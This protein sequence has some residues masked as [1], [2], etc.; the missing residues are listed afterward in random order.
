MPSTLVLHPQFEYWPSMKVKGPVCENGVVMWQQE[1]TTCW[2]TPLPSTAGTGLLFQAGGPSSGCSQD[3]SK[4]DTPNPV[5]GSDWI[6][7]LFRA[8]SVFCPRVRVGLNP[9]EWQIIL[10][11]K[12]LVS[13]ISPPVITLTL[14]PVFYFFHVISPFNQGRHLTSW[15]GRKAKINS[16]EF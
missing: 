7:C 6:I 14:P 3:A 16:I 2:P 12:G 1:R 4:K 13:I 9:K 11:Y 10:I 8:A 5:T 15:T